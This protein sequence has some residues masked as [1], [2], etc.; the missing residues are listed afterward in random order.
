MGADI[1]FEFDPEWLANFDRSDV[2][3]AGLLEAAREA[4]RRAPLFAPWRT[5]RYA[6]SFTVVIEHGQV[7]LGNTNFK[8]HW[9]EFGSVNNP[10]SAPL[11]RGVI[12]AGFRFAD[13]RR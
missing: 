10:V 1:R 11:R 3:E 5:G 2:G 12:A 4:A 13:L 6:R 8:A 9:I 7:R